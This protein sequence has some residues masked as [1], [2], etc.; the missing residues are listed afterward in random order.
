ML[1]TLGGIL[2]LISV[3]FGAFTEHALRGQVSDE[4]LR[5]LMTAIR[6]NQV[7]A[8]MLSVLALALL[9]SPR[10]QLIRAFSWS[11][12]LFAAGTFLFSFSIYAA[13][14]LDS[15]PLTYI[16]PVGGTLLML[17]WLVFAWAGYCAAKLNAE[18]Q[19]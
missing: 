11:A 5:F 13:V 7:H 1:I 16:T 18:T 12:Y 15:E 17:A 9:M 10:L 2:G 4:Y 3:A 19:E 14:L 6:Y 8:V